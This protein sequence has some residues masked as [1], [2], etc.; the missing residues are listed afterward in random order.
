[1]GKCKV[2]AIRRGQEKNIRY[3]VTNNLKLTIESFLKKR[4][5]HW[6][7]ETLHDTIK[8]YMGLGDCYSGIISLVLEEKI[9]KLQSFNYGKP[10]A[11]IMI[12]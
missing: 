5:A 1:M 4:R 8:N 9:S 10:I 11:F 7:V 2:F 12:F 3:Y 6:L